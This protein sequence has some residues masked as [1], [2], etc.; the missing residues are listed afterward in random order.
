[1]GI[2]ISGLENRIKELEEREVKLVR[3]LKI[4]LSEYD[5]H[6]DSAWCETGINEDVYK[7]I[8]D[9]LQEIEINATNEAIK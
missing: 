3:A 1:M 6:Y 5:K 4:L 7:N 8:Q 2:Y 9:F